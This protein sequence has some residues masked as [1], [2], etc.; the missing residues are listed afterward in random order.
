MPEHYEVVV[1]PT[2]DQETLDAFE[3][4]EQQLAGLGERFLQALESRYADL[5]TKPDNYSILAD[6]PHGVLRDVSLKRFPFNVI[7]EIVDDQVIVYSIH[8][9]SREF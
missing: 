6:D 9:T 1:T 3:Y 5:A 8:H 2:A 7:F 4:Y